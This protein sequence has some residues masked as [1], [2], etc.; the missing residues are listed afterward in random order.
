MINAFVHLQDLGAFKML[1]HEPQYSFKK[2]YLLFIYLYN[3]YEY[4]VA[5]FRHTPEGIRFHY[6]WL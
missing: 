1:I 2:I 5:V 4:T 3:I 6:R